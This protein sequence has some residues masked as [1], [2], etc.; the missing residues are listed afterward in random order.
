MLTWMTEDFGA[1]ALPSPRLDAEVL[2]A[3]ALGVPRL[4]LYLEMERPLDEAEKQAVRGLVQR[5]RGHEPV[6]YILGVREFYSRSFAVDKRVLIP[7]PDTE[8]LV[9]VA[10]SVLP[11]GATRVLDLCTGSGCVGLTL[12]AE[13]PEAR[14]CITD[15]SDGALAVARH[16]AAELGV[17]ERVEVLSGDLFG[18]VS[19]QAAFDVI[20][21]NPP[22]VSASEHAE[23]DGD[24]RDHEPR[25]A[26]VADDDGLAF[27]RRI[28]RQAADHLSATGWLVLEVGAGQA[29]AVSGLLAGTFAT[30]R[31]HRD[32][33]G[34]ARVVS[35]SR[36]QPEPAGPEPHTEVV[37]PTQ[38]L[39]APNPEPATDPEPG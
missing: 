32:L 19:D 14:V 21:I 38:D 11:Q 34:I 18:A 8:T 20:T 29:A 13:R 24:V 7:R 1:R 26:L 23:L 15:V 33:G 10:L 4:R 6:A 30:I 39:M 3:H 22:Y 25:L 5:R 35:A 17:A 31:E 12:A 16:N 28:A 36:M 37:E 9:D 27:Y 2:L